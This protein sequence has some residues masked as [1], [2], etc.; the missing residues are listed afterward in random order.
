[1]DRTPLRPAYASATLSTLL[2]LLVAAPAFGHVDVRPRLV[3]QG[4]ETALRIELPQ[5]RPG[6]A[7]VRLELEGEGV[8]V[9]SSRLQGFAAAETRWSVRLRVSPSVAPGELPLILRAVFADGESVEVDGGIVVVPGQMEASDTFPWAGV[10]AGVTLAIG[11]A[12]G[13]VLIARRR[14]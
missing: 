2:L 8:E 7:P 9:L 14:R 10:A 5:L 6:P 13:F 3:E 12:V 11:F 4:M 1:M